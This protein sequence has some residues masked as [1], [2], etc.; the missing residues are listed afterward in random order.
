MST[1]KDEL[2]AIRAARGL[3]TPATVLDAA[4]PP[5]SP[6]HSRFEWD[7]GIAAEKYRLAQ[8]SDLIRSVRVNFTT[9]T[10]VESVRQFV[11]S[12]PSTYSP[13][14][15]VAQ[16]PISRELLLRQFERDWKT[17]Q[18]RYSHLAEFLESIREVLAEAS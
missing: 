12:G 15:E 7:D 2:L 17:F 11:V 10:G 5:E 3:L 8:A 18:A 14:E 13:I 9:A 6:L 1:L 4:R 16:D